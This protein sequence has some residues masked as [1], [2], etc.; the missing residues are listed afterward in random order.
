M[1]QNNSIN[2]RSNMRISFTKLNKNLNIKV[3]LPITN[4]NNLNTINQDKLNR[5]LLV[6]SML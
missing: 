4:N 5:N 1:K 2:K 6:M 3:M